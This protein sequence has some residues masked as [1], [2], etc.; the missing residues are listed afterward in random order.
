MFTGS[1]ESCKEETKEEFEKRIKQGWTS[2]MASRLRIG[3]LY[4]MVNIIYICYTY[5]R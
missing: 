3:E 2:E 4:I 1:Q 5:V